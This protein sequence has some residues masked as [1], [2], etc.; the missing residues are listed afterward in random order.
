MSKCTFR[1]VEFM[2][3]NMKQTGPQ[4]IEI[5]KSKISINPDQV[6]GVTH[7]TIP[8]D[9][10]GPNGNPVGVPAAALI[11]PNGPVVVECTKQE[12]EYKLMT[13]CIKLAP[14]LSEEESTSTI[15]S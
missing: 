12:A 5:S 13:E 15:L 14:S 1:L 9:I 11:L 10:K 7:A 6:G 4:S 2:A 8:S 3:V